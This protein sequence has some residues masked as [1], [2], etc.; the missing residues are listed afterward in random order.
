MASVVRLLSYTFTP[1]ATIASDELTILMPL[2]PLKVDPLRSTVPVE[3]LVTVELFAA[4]EGSPAAVRLSIWLSRR[5]CF[6]CLSCVVLGLF[7]PYAVPAT[8]TDAVTRVQIV[9]L[10]TSASWA[11]LNE[12]DRIRRREGL[13]SGQS[14][15]PPWRSR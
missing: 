7:W 4:I 6:P 8:R 9:L 1:F 3:E 5:A 2:A 13:H 15:A 10:F 11:L 12:R 14:D